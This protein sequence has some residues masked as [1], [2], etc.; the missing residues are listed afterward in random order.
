[1]CCVAA[2]LREAISIR[3]SPSI[4]F[5][6]RWVHTCNV[7]AYR[8]TVTLQ[9]TD[10]IR[11]YELNFLPVPHGVTV[12]CELYTTGFP[13]S[14]LSP[15]DVFAASNGFVHLYTLRFKEELTAVRCRVARPHLL[16][17]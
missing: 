13:V 11:S 16:R 12:S 7:T 1:M 9:V 6:L 8:D 15:W 4:Y 17:P 2:Y 5:L 14:Y 10:T 3:R